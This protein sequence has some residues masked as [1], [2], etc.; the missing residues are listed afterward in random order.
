MDIHPGDILTAINGVAVTN[1]DQVN[2]IVYRL[3]VGD[4]VQL[5]LYRSRTQFNLEIQLTEDKG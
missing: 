5:Q 2:A 3:E 4:T 1:M